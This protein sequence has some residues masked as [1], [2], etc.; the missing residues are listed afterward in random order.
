MS[1]LCVS[2]RTRERIDSKSCK[3]RDSFLSLFDV[4]SASYFRHPYT[5]NCQFYNLFL[6]DFTALFHNKNLFI[7]LLSFLPF[8]SAVI[9]CVCFFHSF[10]FLS[11]AVVV[12]DDVDDG[13]R[14]NFCN[15]WS[16]FLYSCRQQTVKKS[17]IGNGY[18]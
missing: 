9:L 11:P 5:L 16:V 4:N 2:E 6:W 15:G 7:F 17:T 12:T 8:T 10:S 13:K 18:N 3:T 14:R 1:M